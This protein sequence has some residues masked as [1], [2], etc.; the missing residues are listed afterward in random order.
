MLRAGELTSVEL[1][2]AGIEAADRRDGALGVYLTRMDESALE[3]AERADAELR[4]GRD[5]GALHGI[6]VGVK[7]M[8]AVAGV[9]TTAQSLV[10]ADAPAETADA[11]VV[12]RLRAAGAVITGKTTT[13][14]FGCGIPD[15]SKPFPVPRNP[16]NLDR[17]A[18]G[19]SSG[20][21][22]GVAAGMF[23]AALGGDTA[24]SI[25]MPAAFCGVTGLLPSYGRVPRSG[26][27]P[28]GY[29]LGRIGPLARTARDCA[30]VLAAIVGP[31]PGDPAGTAV[32][33]PEVPF[34]D[35]RGYGGDLAG[36]R[37]GLVR[38]LPPGSDPALAGRLADVVAELAGLGASVAEVT[39]P[40]WSELIGAT[41]VTA[42]CE[43]LAQHRADLRAHWADYFPASRGLLASGALFTGADYVQAQRV[44]RLAAGAVAELFGR[45]E[46]VL[47]P[48]AVVGAPPF[49]ALVTEAGHQD[50]AGLFGQVRTPYWNALG[51]PVVAVPIGPAESGLPLSVQL[52]GP[53]FGDTTILRVADAFQ[54]HTE[55]HLRPA[56]KV[57]GAAA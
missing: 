42:V 28:L 20:S 22:S 12:A 21:A 56:A 1:V 30:A 38:D 14:E 35:D 46:V 51:N 41:I 2:E 37:V 5:R 4:A 34:D 13:M 18:G 26:S 8:I 27:V 47:T 53:V 44:R 57:E 10:R 55:W 45:V 50:N 23:L 33:P 3:E 32:P 16:Y 24:G 43:G 17:W 54:R 31:H 6:P 39:L 15:P 19:S 49:D 9:P 48:T 52:A 11:P 7:D 25:R 29:S 40:Y 36:L